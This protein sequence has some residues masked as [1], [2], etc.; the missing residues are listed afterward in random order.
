MCA[1][2]EDAIPAGNSVII[3]QADCRDDGGQKLEARMSPGDAVAESILELVQEG[4]KLLPLAL[5]T[6]SVIKRE[7]YLLR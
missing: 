5:E 6:E 2:R 3:C 7:I 4:S 1:E